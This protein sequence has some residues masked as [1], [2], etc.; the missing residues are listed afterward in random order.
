MNPS[1][2]YF[3]GARRI[4]SKTTSPFFDSHKVRSFSRSCSSFSRLLP[5]CCTS[6]A[7]SHTSRSSYSQICCH[8]TSTSSLSRGNV[9]IQKLCISNALCTWVAASWSGVLT[10]SFKQAWFLSTGG[11]GRMR[12]AWWRAIWTWPVFERAYKDLKSRGL[13][14]EVCVSL[15]CALARWLTCVQRVVPLEACRDFERSS[16]R[17]EYLK[18][19][20]KFRQW[21]PL[22]ATRGRRR[23]MK[24]A[25]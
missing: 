21:Y 15:L 17:T 25:S 20:R 5:E 22:S 24:R 2:S 13:K 19:Y 12:R 8:N 10:Q 23:S 6:S 4:M 1:D 11:R 3:D 18:M 9:S 16:G 7:P 14:E